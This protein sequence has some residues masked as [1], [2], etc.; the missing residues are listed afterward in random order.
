MYNRLAFDDPLN[1]FADPTHDTLES[2][3]LLLAEVGYHPFHRRRR[4]RSLRDSR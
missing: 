4:V 1:G 2:H 3:V